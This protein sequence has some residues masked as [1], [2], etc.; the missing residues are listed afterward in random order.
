MT[1]TTEFQESELVSWWNLGT[2][3]LCTASSRKQNNEAIE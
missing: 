1:S 3:T 2:V